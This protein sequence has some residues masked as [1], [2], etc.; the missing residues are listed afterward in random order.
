MGNLDREPFTLCENC[1]YVLEKRSVPFIPISIY[2][3]KEK[4]L[5]VMEKYS[6]KSILKGSNLKFVKMKSHARFQEEIIKAFN[7]LA[8]IIISLINHC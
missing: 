7:Q 6:L 8:C 4:P 1:L 3:F 2:L 5:Q